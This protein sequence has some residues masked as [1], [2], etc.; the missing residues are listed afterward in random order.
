MKKLGMLLALAALT[1][2][3]MS[4][5]TNTAAPEPAQVSSSGVETM[6][7]GKQFQM[8]K[9]AKGNTVEQE[10]ILRKQVITSDPTRVMWMHLVALDGHMYQRI[11]VSSKITSSGKRLEPT[12]CVA[13]YVSDGSGGH[14]EYGAVTPDKQHYTN[15]LLQIDGTYGSSNAYVF[16]FDPMGN[17]FEKGDGYLLSTIPIDIENPIDKITGLFRVS[18]EAQAAQKNLEAILAK[19]LANQK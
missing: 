9:N 14:S 18:A 17:Y 7:V 16:W 8:P 2:S 13:G 12:T 1:L 19:Q 5:G 4:C 6:E 3:V 11:A 10:Q 15:E